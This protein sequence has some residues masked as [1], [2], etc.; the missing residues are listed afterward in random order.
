MNHED[1]TRE[2]TEQPRVQETVQSPL[3]LDHPPSFPDSGPLAELSFASTPA[4]I[5]SLLTFACTPSANTVTSP[6]SSPYVA[7]DVDAAA[8]EELYLLGTAFETDA[9]MLNT[10]TD[11]LPRTSN[12]PRGP[13]GL[14]VRKV[15]FN[16]PVSFIFYRSLPYGSEADDLAAWARIEG[17]LGPSLVGG[18]L[19]K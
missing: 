16:P 5:S 17:L 7:L 1:E 8:D 6:E 2:R 18:I 4:S 13:I 3:W 11:H 10:M 14:R 9:L 19:Y 12:P 15:S